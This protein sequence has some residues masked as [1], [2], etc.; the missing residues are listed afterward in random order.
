MFCLHA[1]KILEHLLVLPRSN[2]FL[3]IPVP[4]HLIVEC[5][6]PF[7]YSMRNPV[8]FG[9]QF[10]F[11]LSDNLIRMAP[12]SKRLLSALRVSNDARDFG[13]PRQQRKKHLVIA[14]RFFFT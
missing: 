12:K 5:L 6:D 3:R 4:R 14:L 10:L 13:R 11:D 7:G 9:I 8:Q 1:Q 2:P